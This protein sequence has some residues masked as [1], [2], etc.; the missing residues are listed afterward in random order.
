MKIKILITFVLIINTYL[1][2]SQNKSIDYNQFVRET[3]KNV[4]EGSKVNI[5][6][7]IPIE[8]WDITLHKNNSL[9][10]DQ[11]QKFLEALKPYS[12]FAVVDAEVGVLGGFTYKPIDSINA[13]IV[14]LDNYNKSFKP[15]KFD[16][17]DVNVQ[18]LLSAFKPMLKNVM[19]QLGENM[20]FFVFSDYDGDKRISNPYSKGYV[21]IKIQDK[22]YKWRTPLG[23]LLPQ[24]SCPKDGELMNGA[25]DFCPWDG[26]KLVEIKINIA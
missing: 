16:V 25:W 5:V 8:F 15:L 3:Q 21:V 26:E 13:N 6:W 9:A 14:L 1:T 19:G 20:N 24:K 2:F 23:T 22:E 17:L 4:S 12:I 18:N 11:I 10:E 7:W